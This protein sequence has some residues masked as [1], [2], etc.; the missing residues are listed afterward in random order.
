[1]KTVSLQAAQLDIYICLTFIWSHRDSNL[2]GTWWRTLCDF[3]WWETMKGQESR[4]TKDSAQRDSNRHDHGWNQ[5][6]TRKKFHN[7]NTVQLTAFS[8]TSVQQTRKIL[9]PSELLPSGH[10]DASMASSVIPAHN[11]GVRQWPSYSIFHWLALTSSP[12]MLYPTRW[13]HVNS[14][15]VN[16][17]ND[18]SFLNSVRWKLVLETIGPRQLV[19]HQVVREHSSGCT[20][21]GGPRACPLLGKETITPDNQIRLGWVRLGLFLTW[22]HGM[23]CLN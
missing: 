17:S 8:V 14:S 22:G 18:N 7:P 11:D 5:T 9:L 13:H 19:P 4:R 23:S 16:S 20:T 10:F 6:L 15:P 21:A 3:L 1:M 2:S 12:S